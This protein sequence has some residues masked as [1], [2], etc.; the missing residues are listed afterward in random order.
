M[1][2]SSFLHYILYHI[3][4]EP[5]RLF[6]FKQFLLI[7]S[8][9]WCFILATIHYTMERENKKKYC[10]NS[11]FYFFLSQFQVN[12]SSRLKIVYILY[13]YFASQ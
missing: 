2:K 8:H 1:Q 13:E 12:I 4:V 10:N 5:L 7:I 9:N 6:H 11:I 3:L